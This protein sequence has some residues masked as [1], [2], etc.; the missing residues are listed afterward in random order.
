MAAIGLLEVNVPHGTDGPLLRIWGSSLLLSESLVGSVYFAGGFPRDAAR[1]T[2]HRRKYHIL[3][4]RESG[5][6]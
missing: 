6:G 3:Q 5:V 4:Y 2:D 1:I